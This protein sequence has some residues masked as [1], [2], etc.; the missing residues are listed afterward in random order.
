MSPATDPRGVEPNIFA[1]ASE[2]GEL[3]RAFNWSAT[4]IGAP[5]QWSPAL[6]TTVRIMLA[7]RFPML[8][9]WGPDYI[10]LY[11]DAYRPILGKK[12][13]WGLGKPFREC[14]SEVAHI[15]TPLIDRPFY[16]G[17]AT[18]SEDIELEIHRS[19][20]DEETHFTIAYSPVPDEAA[21]GG[22]GGVLATVQEITEKVVG[23][24][25]LAVLRDLGA[26]ALEAG[27]AEE[28]CAIAA[29]TLATHRKDI[30]FALLYVADAD[31]KQA[32]LAGL[33]G[34]ES[35]HENLPSAVPL[36]T[37][38]L[39]QD[40]KADPWGLARAQAAGET[41]VVETPGRAAVLP[42]RA[43]MANRVAG[44]LVA[45]ISPVLR[46]DVEYRNF[47]ELVS[48]RIGISI[49]NAQALEEE[50]RRV[51]ALA[52]IDRTKT[53]FFANVSHEFRTPLTLMLGPLE[54]L[55]ASDSLRDEE[56]D[57]A[58]A[59]HRNSLRLL[60]LVNSL[61]DF[62]RIEAGRMRA[63]YAPADLA[64]LTTDLASNFCSA[65]ESAG[66]EFAIDCA[67]LGEDVYVDGEMWEKVILNLISNAFKFTLHGKVSVK[68]ER[69]GDCARL[70]VADTGTGIAESE[71]PRVF[72]RFYRVEGAKGRTF[73]GAG[74]GLATVRELVK[75]HGGSVEVE[76]QAGVGSTFAVSIP[77]GHGHLPE[78]QIREKDAGTDSGLTQARAFALE[79]EMWQGRETKTP[80][81][82]PGSRPSVLIADDNADM[83]EHLARILGDAYDLRLFGDGATAL[84]AARSAPPDL[85]LS[86]VMMPRADGFE[87]LREIRSD[88]ALSSLPVL[89]LSARAGVEART[90]GIAAGADDYI[91]KPFSARELLARV[92]TSIEL[93]R[94]RRRAR[95]AVESLNEELRRANEDLEQFAYSASHDLQ[96]P[97]RGVK[98]Y[99]ELLE[100]RLQGRLDE[101]DTE[102]LEFLRGSA[103][104]LETLVKDLLSYTQLNRG[105]EPGE[106]ESSKAALD[107]AT[108]NLGEAVAETRARVEHGH[109]PE[110]RVHRAHLQ[111]LFQNLV[112][113]AIK[114]RRP[115]VTP[116]VHVSA[117][118]L[119]GKWL[120]AVRDNGIGI[121]EAYRER[122]FGLF[123]RLHSDGQYAGTGIGLAICKRI[124]ERYEGRIWVESE[125]GKGSTFYFTLP[126]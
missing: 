117:R 97:L 108:A 68:L 99:S 106:H 33:S 120:F 104:R 1:H 5:E 53:A 93:H 62:S 77:F 61:L 121:E 67:P 85:I 123:K 113:N 14:W 18:W 109:L 43:T 37:E 107:A 71:L 28:A 22:I 75:L 21:P 81:A 30:P 80:A 25:R 87:L 100:K 76:S 118:R 84:E 46:F 73:E 78:T 70:T 7:N 36:R 79:A 19:G 96:E 44:F 103:S 110:V 69:A 116:E 82:S 111:L 31:G 48:S 27:T 58:E 24:R 98:I 74:I 95:E 90:G 2:M 92:R 122:I 72:E 6:K 65:M 23:N 10:S 64:E 12:H 32:S 59:A 29:E 60:K 4:G 56:R 40:T 66:L 17:P 51:E 20:F 42:I 16:G 125:P 83:R 41:L 11:N 105:Q 126:A 57:Q 91:T 49:A 35:G 88:C 13:P 119:N 94:E 101:K 52:E 34:M 50:R 124:A 39:K 54:S 9:W 47:L 86:D 112:G 114:Y 26:R 102:Y 45:G 15:L 63:S 3:M 55:L 38:S 115:D 89:L 8:L